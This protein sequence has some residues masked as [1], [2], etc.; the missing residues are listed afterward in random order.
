MIDTQFWAVEK[1]STVVKRFD[2]KGRSPVPRVVTDKDSFSIRE[3]TDR[4]DLDSIS[5]NAD[6]L[7]ENEKKRLS[8]PR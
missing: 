2:T 4:P 6:V 3:F 5:V 7:T 8:V 1:N